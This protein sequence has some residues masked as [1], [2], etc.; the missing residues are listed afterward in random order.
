[1]AGEVEIVVAQAETASGHR[2]G[3][4]DGRACD[5]DGEP[6]GRRGGARRRRVPAVRSFDLRKP[7]ALAR[8]HVRRALPDHQP[9]GDAADRLDP[10]AAARPGSRATSRKPTGSAR[11]PSGRLPPTSR[12]WRRPGSGRTAIAEE[13]RTSIRTDI[14]GKRPAVEADLSRKVAEAETAIQASK[15]EALKSVD[16]IAADTAAELVSR[17]TGEAS[18]GRRPGGRCRRGEGIRPCPLGLTQPS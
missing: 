7:A 2:N 15:T 5:G 16:E 4:R 14:D 6:R 3:G 12:R 8:D 10:R 11:R 1:M 17:I 9:G 18:R 13:T